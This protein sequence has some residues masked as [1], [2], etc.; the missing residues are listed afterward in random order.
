MAQVIMNMDEYKQIEELQD[1]EVLEYL[2]E[3][4]I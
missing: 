4:I 1:E 2:D 3:A